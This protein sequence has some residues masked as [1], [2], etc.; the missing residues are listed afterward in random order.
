LKGFAPALLPALCMALTLP[1]AMADH[2]PVMDGAGVVHT[3]TTEPWTRD[4]ISGGTV[5][6]HV[7][8]APDGTESRRFV[9]GTDNF[10]VE[11]D[12][13]IDI[14]PVSDTPVLV[15]TQVTIRASALYIAREEKGTWATPHLIWA[16]G[17][18]NREPEID[19][20]DNLLHMI[21][22]QDGRQPVRLRLSLGRETLTPAFGPEELP[23]NVEGI[24]L[25]GDDPG[26]AD[27]PDPDLSYFASVIPQ[28]APGQ[29]GR[30]ITWGIRDEPVPVVYF[31]PFQLPS[32]TQSVGE[33]NSEWLADRFVT[34]FTSGSS[35]YYTTLNDG[36]W[37]ELKVID[38]SDGRSTAE[39]LL[40]LQDLIRR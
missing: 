36:N 14:D 27:T 1:C 11:Q 31:Q 40:M 17:S 23:V 37:D 22:S 20:R 12:P 21:W 3:V 13:F 19:V 16:D 29:P 24:A 28:P 38:L 34:W 25:P 33:Q 35:F 39:A 2:S 30:I 5:L 26:P 9:H 18:I 6:V 7:T 10:A 15:W 32:G 4:D 8:R